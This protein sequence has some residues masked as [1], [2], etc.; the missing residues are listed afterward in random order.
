MNCRS[1]RILRRLVVLV[2]SVATYAPAR[3]ARADEIYLTAHQAVARALARN[4]DLKVFEAAPQLTKA[5]E[6]AAEATFE[7]LLFAEANAN[8]SPGQFSPQRAG[9]SPTA[10]TGIGGTIGMRKLFAT[11]T[12]VEVSLATQALFGAG[13]I[14]PAYQSSVTLT[15]RQSL[16]SGISRKANLAERDRARLARRQ[17]LLELKRKAE[18]TASDTLEA[19][20]SL[21][22]ALAS[23]RIQALAVQ[24]TERSLRETQALIAA[25]KVAGTEEIAARYALQV[26]R[27]AKLQTGQAVG[28]A[29]DRLARVIGLVATDSLV[30]PT[31]V[32]SATSAA[33]LDP[34]ALERLQREA[35]GRRGDL[36]ALETAVKAE[37]AR[38]AAADHRTLPKLDVVGSVFATGLSGD[39]GSA[40][41][42]LID[43][44]G[45][46]GSSFK[47]DQVGWS[48]GLVLELPLG[49]RKARAAVSDAASALR[50]AEANLAALRQRIALELNVALRSLR[51]AEQQL[52]LSAAAE[53]LAESKLAAERARYTAGKSTA[54]IYATVQAELVKEQQGQVQAAAELHQALARLHAAAGALLLQMGIDATRAGS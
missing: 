13:I 25:G 48:A 26:Q 50:Q 3:A 52:A 41:A 8:R 9:L 46:Y 44:A 53:R 16:L 20:F 35:F 23:D 30:T 38:L 37:R 15:A 4:L 49:N 14:D 27:R 19:Y 32:T 28:N 18:Q 45:G 43:I 2:A 5:A 6:D 42:G 11:G 1:A 54:H 31:I 29:R 34:K 47:M 22:A 12:S 36:I 51:L 39:V 24:T 33:A 21:H 7:P 40:T 17:A 10:L